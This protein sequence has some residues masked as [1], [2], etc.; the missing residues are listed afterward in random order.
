MILNTVEQTM[1]LCLQDE[2]ETL[3]HYKNIFCEADDSTCNLIAGQQENV[4]LSLSDLKML[5]ASTGMA[6]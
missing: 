2:L 1:R 4:A 6:M 3:T 5:G